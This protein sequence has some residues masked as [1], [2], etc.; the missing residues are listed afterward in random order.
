MSH[1]GRIL[2]PARACPLP[3]FDLILFDSPP[4]TALSYSLL[5]FSSSSLL[6]ALLSRALAGVF[7]HSQ[8][9]CKALLCDDGVTSGVARSAALARFNGASSVGFIVGPIIGGHLLH[10]L[11]YAARALF[12]Q[13][14][15]HER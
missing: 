5:G 11:P 2:L 9:F 14:R 10:A 13:R 1:F 12:P 8:T 6:W 7:K 3:Q 4:S 15:T